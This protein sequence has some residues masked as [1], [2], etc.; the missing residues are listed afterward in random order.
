MSTASDKSANDAMNNGHGEKIANTEWHTVTKK[1]QQNQGK[2][3]GGRRTTP[4]QLQQM[5]TVRLRALGAELSK[6]VPSNEM[7][8]HQLGDNKMPRI[9]C[10]NENTKEIVSTHLKERGIQFNSFNNSETRQKSFIIRGLICDGDDEAI[11]LI[12]DAVTSMGVVGKFEIGKHETAYQR[13]HPST[14]RVP[15]FR[16][17]VSAAVSDQMLIDI[18]TIG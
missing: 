17:T 16:I 6:K 3:A 11:E 12:H 15:L 14:N 4:I 2:S 18:R 8:V 13:Y 10:S 5:D 7:Y 1:R 9:I